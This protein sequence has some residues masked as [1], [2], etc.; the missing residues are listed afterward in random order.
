MVYGIV[1]QSHGYVWVTSRPGE[2]TRFDIYLPVSGRAPDETESTG[3]FRL[4]TGGSETILLVED[5]P[6]VR[7][8]A[9]RV[10]EREGYRVLSAND[11]HHALET[12]Q[13]FGEPID[14]VVTD[15]VM[16]RMGGGQLAAAYEQLAPGTPVLFMSGHSEGT[17]TT[18]EAGL[19]VPVL[20]KP[21]SPQGLA[22]A[23]RD[24]LD[25][26]E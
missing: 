9:C 18:S 23:V 1:K 15:V 11:G 25:G 6:A 10:L 21:F 26:R 22:E 7:D 5:E 16:P 12:A 4:G 24:A 19:G 2:G 8:L 20:R 13:S 3:P 17:Q 14:L